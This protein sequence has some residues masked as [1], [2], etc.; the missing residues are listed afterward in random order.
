MSRLARLTLA[1]LP[2]IALVACS[3]SDP[4]VSAG[5]ATPLD[6]SGSG[7]G[8]EPNGSAPGSSAASIEWEECGELLE[9][10]T[11]SVPL[12][13]ADPE[14]ARIQLA[15]TRH[16]ARDED[17]RIGSLLV[18]PGGP[19]VGARWLAE[20]ADQMYGDALLDRFDIVAWDPRGVGQ[21]TPT[22]DCV[23]D[24]DP[25]FSLDPTPDDAAEQTALE[26]ASAEYASMCALRSGTDLLAHVS[27]PDAARDMDLIRQ[28]LGEDTISYF[29]FSYGSELGATWA[30]LFPETVRAAVLDSSAA[31]NADEVAQAIDDAEA[32]DAA[33]GRFFSQ[34]A[35]DRDCAFYNDGSPAAAYSDLM[36]SLEREPL[37]VSSD[38]PVVNEAVAAYAVIN[39]MYDS[40]SWPELAEQLAAAQD[41]DGSGLLEAYDT[42]LLRNDD[43]TYSDEFDAFIAITCADDQGPRDQES[44]DAALD[45]MG[46]AA[47][48]LGGIRTIPYRCAEWAVPPVE[49]IEITGAGAGPVLVIGSSG[50]PIT[51][52]TSSRKMA[53]ALEGGVLVTVE[54]EQHIAYGVNECGDSAVEDYLIDLEVPEDGTICD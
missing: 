43:G 23:D 42:F 8:S 54:A 22:I 12:D 32:L 11:L 44:I 35:D 13:H 25:Y 3:S 40:S 45:E 37:E 27:T 21:S 51:P 48:L 31:P 17:E 7:G 28:A 9:C 2:L 14:G 49:A 53:D 47:P 4:G 19:G 34:C 29:G 50:D 24:L 20:L 33:L 30:T 10:G 5:D 15:M 16:L 36:A 52:I 6:T 39:A 46:Q 26:E 41:G 38:R 18:N 1:G